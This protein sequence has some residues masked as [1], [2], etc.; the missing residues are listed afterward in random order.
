MVR[1]HQIQMELDRGIGV[2]RELGRGDATRAPGVELLGRHEDVGA[3]ADVCQTGALAT[4][5]AGR[6]PC[7]TAPHNWQKAHSGSEWTAR[8]C[9]RQALGRGRLSALADTS[10]CKHGIPS[11]FDA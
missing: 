8:T 11:L 4:Q 6:R 7:P 5:G 9:R 10:S 2:A 1:A 3:L